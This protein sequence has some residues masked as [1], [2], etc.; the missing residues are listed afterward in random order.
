MS[1]IKYTKI[2]SECPLMSSVSILYSNYTDVS[3]ITMKASLKAMSSIQMNSMWI[4]YYIW[5]QR[6]LFLLRRTGGE[7]PIFSLLNF[8]FISVFIYLSSLLTSGR[9]LAFE[10]YLPDLIHAWWSWR[11]KQFYLQFRVFPL[12]PGDP[13]WIDAILM[14]VFE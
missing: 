6:I 12:R 7:I 14:V 10:Y 8:F 2:S 5:L 3:I 1:S 4:E 13:I 9:T 11:E